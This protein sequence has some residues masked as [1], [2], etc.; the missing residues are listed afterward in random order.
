MIIFREPPA[1]K[2]TDV[3]AVV[4]ELQANPN[5]WGIVRTYKQEKQSAAHTYASHINNGRF[6]GFKGCE[7][8]ACTEPDGVHVY[9]R[10]VTDAPA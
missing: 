6:P 7:A 2:R 10:W 3:R 1:R 9:A 8:Y 4:A 5:E